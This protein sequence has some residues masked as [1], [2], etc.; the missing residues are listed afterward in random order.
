MPSKLPKKQNVFL[1][2]LLFGWGITGGGFFSEF[3]PRNAKSAQPIHQRENIR[4]TM[5]PKRIQ[6]KRTA[7][8]ESQ[9]AIQDQAS[10]MARFAFRIKQ[11]C[12]THRVHRATVTQP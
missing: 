10:V 11:I 2:I 5:L 1:F 7:R 8:A 3:Y 9:M 6:L 12:D 4:A